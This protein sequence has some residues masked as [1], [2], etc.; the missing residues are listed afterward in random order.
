MMK[1]EGRVSMTALKF[2][3]FALIAA[4]AVVLTACA[5]QSAGPVS[6]PTAASVSSSPGGTQTTVNT[7]QMSG[8]DHSSMQGMS[9]SGMDMNAMMAHCAEM[10]QQA[11]AGAMPPGMQ[12]MMAQCDQMD[13]GPHMGTSHGR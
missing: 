11:R 13:H 6:A 12:Q 8:M 1:T 3:R 10:R 2:A 7:G 5:P 9:H 4:V